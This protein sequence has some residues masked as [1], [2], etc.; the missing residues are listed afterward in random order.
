MQDMPQD[1]QG[2]QPEAADTEQEAQELLAGME[3]PDA[4]PQE[5]M[6]QA[7]EDEPDGDERAALYREGIERLMRDG[8]TE[9]ELRGFAQ[10][11]A[12]HQALMEGRS[13]GEAATAY[14]RRSAAPKKRAV[15]NMRRAGAG[16]AQG[17]NRIEQMTDAQF[18]A[19]SRMA[20]EAALEGRK[21]RLD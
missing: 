3:Q 13:L 4:A 9:G 10:D 1:V 5:P 7:Q 12:V 16:D 15:P 21:I 19:F 14:L 11:E 8:W 18:D 6:Q 20:M 2:M 17:A